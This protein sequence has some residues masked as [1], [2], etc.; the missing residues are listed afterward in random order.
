MAGTTLR[1]F[2]TETRAAK[3]QAKRRRSFGARNRR[4]RSFA[5]RVVR[6]AF[7]MWAAL[8]VG[9]VAVVAVLRWVP[10]PTTS[11]AV[12]WWAAHQ[13]APAHDWVSWGQISPE[14]A[15]A[16]VAAEDQKFPAHSGFDFDA[17]E[18]AIGERKAGSRV[19]GASTITQQVAKNLFLWPDRSWVRKALE[20]WLTIWIELLWPK[21]RILET[22]LNVAQFG[23]GIFGVEAAANAFFRKPAAG[24]DRYESALLAAV[25]PDPERLSAARPSAYVLQRRSWIVDQMRGLGGRAYVTNLQR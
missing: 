14:V 19:R 18:E 11:F 5:G 16:V 17:I 15:L 10:P 22:Y 23:P 20:A 24:L 13:H 21:Q 7:L 2:E 12:Q 25:L 1:R 9:S 8:L 3:P 6:V 4:N